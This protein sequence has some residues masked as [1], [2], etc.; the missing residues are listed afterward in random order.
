MMNLLV[1]IGYCLNWY[2]RKYVVL[3]AH[4]YF[5][6][7]TAQKIRIEIMKRLEINLN[8]TQAKASKLLA[9]EM[10]I[11]EGEVIDILILPWVFYLSDLDIP[12]SEED[13]QDHV[14]FLHSC[15]GYK[16]MMDAKEKE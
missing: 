12:L 1:K 13:Y 11:S 4:I 3:L 15:L 8:D 9:E 10:R 2:I 14:S 7:F 5:G 6:L 16:R